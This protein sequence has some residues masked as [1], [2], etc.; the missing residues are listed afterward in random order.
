MTGPDQP[1]IAT[2]VAQAVEVLRAG[3]LVGMPTETVYGLAADAGNAEAVG[4][5][6]AAKGRPTDHPLIVHLAG[7]DDIGRWAADVPDPARR[8]VERF[9]PGPLTLL[10]RRAPHVLDEVTGGRATV[11][12]RSPD[13]PVA[14]ELLT[15]FRGGLVAPSANRFGRVS[16][17]TAA[18]VVAE[19][20]ESVD[21]VLDGGPCDVG[22]ESTIVDLTGPQPV[23]LRRGAVTPEDLAEVVGTEVRV[24]GTEAEA[25]AP[26]MLASHY[27]PDAAVVVLA[28]DSGDLAVVA[29]AMTLVDDHRSVGV[30]APR[31]ISGLPARVVELEPGG[32]AEHYAQVLY[33]RLRQADALALAHLVVVPPPP[34]GIGAAIHDRLMRAAHRD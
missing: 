14:N 3:G 6:F 1:R 15:R 5:V 23:V 17:T 7:A 33:A 25:V 21:L 9:W 27:A 28:H 8:L 22:L 31:R 10:L 32:E 26:G 18:A 20:G 24:A 4:R 29:A 16:P 34:D 19:L 2:D 13:H 11:A 30:F 12:L